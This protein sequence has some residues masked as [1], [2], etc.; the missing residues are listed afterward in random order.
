MIVST[1]SDICANIFPLRKSLNMAFSGY[2][3]IVQ[4]FPRASLSLLER[5][6]CGSP[7]IFENI[8]FL[9]RSFT[10]AGIQANDFA[11]PENMRSVLYKLAHRL[12]TSTSAPNLSADR[13]YLHLEVFRELGL[14]QEA[15]TLVD[16][17]VGRN[18]CATSLSCNELRREICRTGGMLKEEGE[19]SERLIAEKQ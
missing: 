2:Y 15:V 4:A 14:T 6:E 10:L 17:E 1:T 19:Q 7:G 18:I 13:L 3:E 8:C 5:D 16:S 9:A 11:T 12:L